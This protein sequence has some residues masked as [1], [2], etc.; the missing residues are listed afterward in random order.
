MVGGGG[1]LR[2]VDEEGR[3]AHLP[4]I[5]RHLST[6]GGGGGGSLIRSKVFNL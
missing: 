5:A 1:Y 4:R 3:R 6:K 2:Q